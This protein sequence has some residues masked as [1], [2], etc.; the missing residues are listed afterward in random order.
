[1]A[2]P[3]VF[4]FIHNPE[5]M[6]A[7]FEEVYAVAESRNVIV[8]LSGVTTMTPD[9]IPGLLAT[10]HHCRIGGARIRGNVPT[11][12]KAQKMLNESGFREY[13]HS[14]PGTRR[15]SPM[16]HILKFTA[17]G[18]TSH[19]RFDQMLANGLVE[20]AT[21]KLTGIPKPHGPSFS[22]LGE[23]MLNTLNHAGKYGVSH[24]P[25]WASVYYDSERKRACFTFLD[26]G[27]GIFESHRLTTKLKF[28]TGLQVL[29]PAQILQRLVKGEIPS[30]TREPGR[31]NGIPGMY[32]HCK[33][34][35]IRKLT[36]LSN[37]AFGDLEAETY[38]VLPKSF[39]GTLLYWE[40]L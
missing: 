5:G 37:K 20:F 32:D 4:S 14:A 23:A 17:G 39:A 40:I 33:A 25:W 9:A 2:G 36:I 18:E 34:E 22:V 35:R 26:R 12:L 24:E 38:V 28:L 6:V 31:G 3:E 21:S 7:F 13:V 10:I 8:D 1:V 11:D 30:T 27:V 15:P 29:S 19:D 16:G